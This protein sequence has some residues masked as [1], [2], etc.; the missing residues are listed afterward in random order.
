MPRYLKVAAAQVGRVDRTT[1]RSE[2]LSRLIAL[3]EEASSQNVKLVVFPEETFT[4][5]FP[6]Y[7]LGDEE[8]ATFFEKEPTE[9]IAN[10]ETVKPLFDRATELGIDIH[11]GYGEESPTGERYNSASYVSQGKTVGKHR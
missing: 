11:V 5:F 8:L 10:C 9:G 6:R 7:L 3:L 1:P 2:V 4:T